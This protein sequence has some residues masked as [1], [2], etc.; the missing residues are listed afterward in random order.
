MI[1]SAM[2]L[3]GKRS[4]SY[5]AVLG[6]C[7]VR[8]RFVFPRCMSFFLSRK[9]QKEP[10]SFSYSSFSRKNFGKQPSVG[11][12]KPSVNC[13]LKANQFEAGSRLKS[14]PHK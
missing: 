1:V 5:L 3:K 8:I 4:P 14:D 6:A 11:D 10:S 13:L 9:R 2:G 7:C 12:I